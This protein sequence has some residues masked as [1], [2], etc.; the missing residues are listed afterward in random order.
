MLTWTQVQ[1]FDEILLE[2]EQIRPS[3]EWDSSKIERIEVITQQCLREIC[4]IPHTFELET[5]NRHKELEALQI[6]L[7]L[8]TLELS[9]LLAELHVFVSHHPHPK[10][11]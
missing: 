3:D 5:P 9:S 8:G 2:L 6:Q 11:H 4:T 7:R 1:S 10:L